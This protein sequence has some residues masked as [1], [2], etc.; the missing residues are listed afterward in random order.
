MEPTPPSSSRAALPVLIVGAGLAG[1][2]AAR[3]LHAAGREVLVL[4]ARDRVGGRT[5]AMPALPG[6]P[7]AE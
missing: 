6:R 7:E 3:V 2:T 4:K 5:L 1:L